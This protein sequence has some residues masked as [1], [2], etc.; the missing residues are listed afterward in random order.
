MDR[1]EQ[2]SPAPEILMIQTGIQSVKKCLT[3]FQIYYKTVS[4]IPETLA[5]DLIV[6]VSV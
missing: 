3:D 4:I 5:A 2:F 6:S 1:S